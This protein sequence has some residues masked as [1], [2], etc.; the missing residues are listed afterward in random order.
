M[1]KHW[2]LMT[3]IALLCIT[4]LIVTCLFKNLNNHENKKNLKLVFAIDII[5]HGDRTPVHDLPFFSEHW[6]DQEKG[7]LTKKG[8]K[9]AFKLG[10]D[11]RKD[12]IK[13]KQLL[14]EQFSNH[15]IL[16]KSSNKQRTVET[17]KQITK[18]I[19]PDLRK[20]NVELFNDENN[21][22]LPKDLP[23]SIV[24]T[25]LKN[26]AS[27]EL[28]NE[29]KQTIDNINHNLNSNFT[30]Y[31]IGKISDTI[32]VNESHDIK[33]PKNLSKTNYRNAKKL[34]KIARIV[35]LS[36]H[37]VSCT[38]GSLLLTNILHLLGNKP[39]TH[40]PKYILY[41][42]H[43]AIIMG[44]LNLLDFPNIDPPYL[45]RL[46][47][48]LF[49]DSLGKLYVKL[50]YNNTP[51]TICSA[52]YCELKTFIKTTKTRLTLCSDL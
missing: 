50:S 7:I 37:K 4:T 39:D 14:P 47:I 44:L 40:N 52:E 51:I 25:Y 12:Y 28:I 26:N 11:I 36:S 35:A 38:A 8:E 18:G 32:T 20:V 22:L 43:D 27:S 30:E 42:T 15:S 45:A 46:Q 49:R 16:V 1:I 3:T 29:I 10:Q 31:D 9:E 41:I 34:G 13:D 33:K 19:Y 24:T 21:P 2:K 48:E 6:K 23:L 5:R 17:A